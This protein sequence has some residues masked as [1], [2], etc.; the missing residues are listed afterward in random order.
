MANTKLT[1]MMMQYRQVKSEIPDDAI[2]FFRLGDFYEMFF[3]DARKAS[4]ILDIT[5]TQRGGVPMCGIPYHALENYLPRLLDTGVKVAIAEQVEDPKQ[6][7]GI[8]KREV[9]RIITPGTVVDSSVLSPKQ[10]NF[11][12]AL[13]C[14]KGRYGLACLD[15]ST[16]DFRIT[17]LPGRGE[18][19]T[20]LH[21]LQTK[22]CLL[23][24][25]L[26]D[27]W[28]N[29]E[30]YPY[31]SSKLLWT[32]L[33]DWVF[34]SDTA[35]EMLK[36]HFNVA[37]LDGFGCRDMS[38]A[39]SAAGA[40]LNYATENLRCSASH[41]KKMRTYQSRDYMV[42]DHISQRNLELVEPLAG[43][44][45][46]STLLGVLDETETPMGSRL[47][48][49]WILRPLYNKQEILKRLDA[50][51]ALKDDP[52]SLAEIKEMFSAVRDLERII[53]KLNI[54]SANARDML[55][56]RRSSG[57]IKRSA[58]TRVCFLI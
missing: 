54:G 18:L 8:V 43:G 42:L 15:I 23:P 58:F 1:P 36:R 31:T 50:V 27:T 37:S 30:S 12:V 51:D 32:P 14:E 53:T 4:N 3:E 48:R 33:P 11:L 39:V 9:T 40:V 45:K 52:L 55:S 10:N 24:E 20:E 17:E 21:R 46:A 16:A 19:E 44:S 56:L 13:A 7:K 47:L 34:A 5:F 2:L 41:I 28:G 22:E 6:A 38:L 57:V 35:E 29:E 26:L 25:S 49:E